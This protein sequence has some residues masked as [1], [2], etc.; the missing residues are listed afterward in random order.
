LLKN[1]KILLLDEATSALDSESEYVVQEALDGLLGKGNRTTIVIAHRLSTIRNADVI[2]VVKDGKVAETGSHDE[3]M[4]RV[5]SE[6]A[7]LVSAQTTVRSESHTTL[8]ASL[9]SK[10]VIQSNDYIQAPQIEFK[11]VHFHYPARPSN[12]IFK[13]LNLKI[14]HGETL[15]IV[16]TSGG[17]KSTIIQMI[18]RFYDP[19]SGTVSYEGNDLKDVVPGSNWISFSGTDSFQHDHS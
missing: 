2:A 4:K 1:P 5:G 13:G 19:L 18:E 11:D 15:A 12:E 3:L 14:K 16:G 6:Y 7:K 9:L 17:G 10:S 8:A